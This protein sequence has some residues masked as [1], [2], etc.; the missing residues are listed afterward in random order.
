MKRLIRVKS[1]DIE[2]WG[3]A[4]CAWVFSPSG[5]PVGISLDEMKE[6][7]KLQRDKEFA[8]HACVQQPRVKS[9]QAGAGRTKDEPKGSTESEGRT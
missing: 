9:R 2:G 1:M 6:N 3:C 4:E 5:P 8:S 7:F